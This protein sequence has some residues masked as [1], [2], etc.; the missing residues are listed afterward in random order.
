MDLVVKILQNVSSVM[1][2][3]A[4]IASNCIVHQS[5]ISIYVPL[6][7]PMAFETEANGRLV[8]GHLN[9]Q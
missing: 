8:K 2:V 6:L 3:R 1:A 9:T 5:I 4:R 7:E